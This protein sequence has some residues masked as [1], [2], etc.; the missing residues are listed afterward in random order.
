MA[1][2]LL[3]P[4][5]VHLVDRR[6]IQLRSIHGNRT[7]RHTTH[8]SMI[9]TIINRMKN[10]NA[11]SRC[12]SSVVGKRQRNG[13]KN[14]YI[15]YFFYFYI[16][17]QPKNSISRFPSNIRS[18]KESAFMRHVK[19]EPIQKSWPWQAMRQVNEWIDVVG[20]RA[21]KYNDQQQHWRLERESNRVKQSPSNK[22]IG[23]TY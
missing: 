15:V 13:E 23:K 12:E 22:K 9:K 4:L 11:L 3:V 17:Y 1:P 19:V 18:V 20:G 6:R 14:N 10:T 2:F 8:S 16:R 21:S 7:T 5:I